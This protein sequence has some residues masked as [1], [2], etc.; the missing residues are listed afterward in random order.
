M[1]GSGLF[2][3]PCCCWTGARAPGGAYVYEGGRPSGFC[4]FIWAGSDC[5][6]PLV[7]GG[8]RLVGRGDGVATGPCCCVG[9]GFCEDFRLEPTRF[10]KPAFMDDMGKGKVRL[11][12]AGGVRVVNS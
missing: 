12:R 1:G 5:E 6:L 10:L 7:V 9:V 11:G 8:E 3:R 4:W 2:G